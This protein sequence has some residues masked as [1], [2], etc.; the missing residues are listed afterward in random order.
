[1]DNRKTT[2]WWDVL[3]PPSPM[4]Q[5]ERDKKALA[6]GIELTDPREFAAIQ[7]RQDTLEQRV[8]ELEAWREI[9]TKKQK[10]ELDATGTIE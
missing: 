7:K 2:R 4:K 10:E 1:M 5:A 6:S 9:M 8:D 3:W